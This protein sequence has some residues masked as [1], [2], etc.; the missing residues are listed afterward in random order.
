MFMT[1]FRYVGK[2]VANNF[3]DK[4]IATLPIWL[5]DTRCAGTERH[6]ADCAHSPWGRHNCAHREDVAVS[7]DRKFLKRS[8]I[9]SGVAQPVSSLCI[10]SL[11]FLFLS[12]FLARCFLFSSPFLHC[13]HKM[14]QTPPPQINLAEL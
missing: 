6:I 13:P 12:F 14:P 9:I 2:E 5:D 8:F 11:P 10:F 7:C 1:M 3:T 4:S